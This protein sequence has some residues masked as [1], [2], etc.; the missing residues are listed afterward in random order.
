MWTTVTTLYDEQ[1]AEYLAN[2]LQE[3]GIRT[4]LQLSLLQPGL[5]D[6]RVP[7]GY[8]DMAATVLGIATSH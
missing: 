3:A 5:I 6:L 8:V 1:E 2:V 7:T 4:E